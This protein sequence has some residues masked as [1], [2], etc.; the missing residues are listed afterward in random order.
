LGA[1][2]PSAERAETGRQLTSLSER[3][4]RETAGADVDLSERIF[5]FQ[6]RREDVGPG[7]PMQAAGMLGT[8]GL[9]PDVL[10]ALM[11]LFSPQGGGGMRAAVRGSLPTGRR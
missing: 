7:S 8:L 10:A 1:T 4:R 6:E 9:Q 5:G 11:P 2:L 3:L